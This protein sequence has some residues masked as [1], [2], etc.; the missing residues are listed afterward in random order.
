MSDDVSDD[1]HETQRASEPRSDYTNAE[2]GKSI[3]WDDRPDERA[4]VKRKRREL[5]RTG[6]KDRWHVILNK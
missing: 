4:E 1:D 2:V 6:I 5:E 3:E